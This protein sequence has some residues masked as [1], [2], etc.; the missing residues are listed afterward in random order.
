MKFF[1]LDDYL[2]AFSDVIWINQDNFR[3]NAGTRRHIWINRDNFISSTLE[4][5]P[6]MEGTRRHIWINQDK[7][8]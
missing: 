5:L 2:N 3:S 6:V 8:I 1:K 7:L 4:M